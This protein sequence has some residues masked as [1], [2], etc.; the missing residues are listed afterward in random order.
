MLNRLDQDAPISATV[1]FQV[2]GAKEG[3]FASNLEELSNATRRL[4]GANVF[5]YGERQPTEQPAPGSSGPVEYVIYEDWETVEQFR[6]QW[7]SQHLQKFQAGVG[8][9][10]VAPPDLRF[11][12]GWSESGTRVGVPKTRADALLQHERQDHRLRRHGAGRRRTGRGRL[13]RAALQRQPRRHRDR[14]A[15]AA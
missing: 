3:D 1:V 12:R 6:V 14:Q 9:F 10:L 5:A 7:D 2:D 8:G 4:S 15:H 13:A 11:Y